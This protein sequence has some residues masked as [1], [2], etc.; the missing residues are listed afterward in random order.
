MLVFIDLILYF[1]R[2]QSLKH[3]KRQKI[4]LNSK[5]R[6]NPRW[7]PKFVF[8]MSTE[9]CLFQ[10]AFLHFFFI[11]LLIIFYRNNLNTIKSQDMFLEM[12][13]IDQSMG[14]LQAPTDDR[15]SPSD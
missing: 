11:L 10:N 1:M 7:M 12:S 13:L 8:D 5:L 2:L 4:V 14:Y 3:E 6:Q 9:L 15:I